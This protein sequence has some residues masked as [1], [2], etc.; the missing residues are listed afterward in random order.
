MIGML[1]NFCSCIADL[2]AL[3]E[4]YYKRMDEEH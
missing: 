2:E 1:N 3:E 4:N